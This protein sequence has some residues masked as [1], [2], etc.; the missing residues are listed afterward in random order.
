MDD[1]QLW[2]YLAIVV[3]FVWG[4]F[5]RAALGFGGAVLT[6]PFLLMVHDE[7]LVFLPVV[8]IHLLFFSSLIVIRSY[9]EERRAAPGEAVPTI[10]WHFLRYALAV[11]TIP[12]LL[13]VAGVI[14]LPAE[15][16]SGF[17]FVVVSVLAVGYIL[18]RPFRSNSRALDTFMLV[19]G[20][21]VSG[22]SLM[23][24]PFVVP[25][26]ASRLPREQVRDT[27]FALWFVLVAMKLAAFVLS[28]V[29][30][31]LRHQLW[32]LPCAAVGHLLGLRFHRY[33][34]KADTRVFFRV[35]GSGLLA[36]S[37]VG[38]VRMLVSG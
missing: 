21:Y 12:K 14:L 33:M 37:V 16:V 23:A 32:L 4:G 10:N 31:Q 13:G 8:A 18:D 2:Q 34:L 30:L 27:L 36:V 11:M 38:L 20:A 25:I 7:P 26:V 3:L 19:L 1:L 6:L 35:L 17:I 9:R 28:G 24:A 22:L 15:L 29:D 5:V